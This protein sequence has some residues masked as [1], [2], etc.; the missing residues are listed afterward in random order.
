MLFSHLAALQCQRLNF[1]AD[2]KA[3]TFIEANHWVER[4]M[5]QSVQPEDALHLRKELRVDLPDTPA[6]L[7]MRL[8]LVFFYRCKS[9]SRL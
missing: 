4:A 7:E 6:L 9:H 5:G 8:Q 3:R 1:V 2:Q